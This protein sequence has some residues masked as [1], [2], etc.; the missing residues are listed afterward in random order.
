MITSSLLRLSTFIEALPDDVKEDFAA[1]MEDLRPLIEAERAKLIADVDR[2]RELIF[3]GVDAERA[4]LTADIERQINEVDA[5]VQRQIDEVF[6]RIE[7]LTDDTVNESFAES[8][9]LINLVYQRIFTLLMIALA[10]GAVL[11]VLHKWRHPL[12]VAKASATPP[13]YPDDE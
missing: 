4:A 13:S 3:A 10:G 8:E 11:V 6:V 7:T 9:R 5:N 12:N 2:Q 1:S